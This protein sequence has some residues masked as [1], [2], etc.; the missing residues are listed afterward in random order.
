MELTKKAD[1]LSWNSD[2][3]NSNGFADPNYTTSDR[4]GDAREGGH[5]P[6]HV[7]YNVGSEINFGIDYLAFTIYGDL[8][9]ALMLYGELFVKHL[10]GLEEQKG[11]QFYDGRFLNSS[12]FAILH[13]PRMHHTKPHFRFV[14]PGAACDAIPRETL[15]ELLHKALE[16]SLRLVCTRIDLKIDNCPFR[17]SD[18]ALEIQEGRIRTKADRQTLKIFSQ[19]LELDELGAT[20]TEG[21]YF[22]SR[23]SERFIRIYDAH[24]F[25]RLELECKGDTANYYFL[26]LITS[27]G[28]FCNLIMGYVLDYVDFDANFWK[29]FTQGY[30]RIPMPPKKRI[31]PTLDALEEYLFTQCSPAIGLLAAIKGKKWLE[32]LCKHG[33]DRARKDPKYALLIHSYGLKEITGRQAEDDPAADPD[34]IRGLEALSRWARGQDTN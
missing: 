19:P 28:E 34:Y 18:A 9:D 30:A 8:N 31:D 33:L 21:M 17:P 11:T 25:T 16:R 4:A 5:R 7:K 14:I 23:Q 6:T 12:G 2:R 20:G 15:L 27:S 24:G 26:N 13:T 29:I 3:P 32:Q 22:G 1:D 10:G